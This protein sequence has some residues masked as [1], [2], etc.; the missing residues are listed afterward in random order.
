[1][2]PATA[3]KLA[4]GCRHWLVGV[5]TVLLL[6]S[7]TRAAAQDRP[8][9]PVSSFPFPFRSVAAVN[10]FS[11]VRFNPA[12]LASDY[13][14]EL[15]YLHQFSDDNF[16]GHDALVLRAKTMAA[17]VTWIK[18][19]VFGKRREYLLAGG[20]KISAQGAFGF[21]YRYIKADDD[22]LQNRSLWT[23][24]VQITPTPTWKLGARWENA[25][26][27][28]VDGTETNGMII[29]GLSAR[30]VG[31]KVELSLDWFYPEGV[32]LDETELRLS[33]RIWVT[34]GV[35]ARAFVD[36]EERVGLELRF[37]IERSAA[38]IQVR[39]TDYSDYTAGT[40]YVSARGRDYDNAKRPSGE[41]R[42]F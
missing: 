18:D 13:D 4:F 17:A 32:S 5:T 36:T 6:V 11:S 3:S 39:Y 35:N 40:F 22:A 15:A 42:G 8:D 20:G 38:G 16:G 34:P 41:P 29:S 19:P 26:H 37:P 27:A 31:P 2:P 10:D 23:F 9:F 25:R 28:E 7:A 14:A 30:P 33:G 24:G 21:A 12:G 1:M